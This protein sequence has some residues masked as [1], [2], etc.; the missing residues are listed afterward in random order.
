LEAESTEAKLRSEIDALKQ[1]LVSQQAAHAHQK[2]R[3]S[4]TVLVLI[5]L[6]VVVAAVGAFFTGF[7]PHQRRQAALVAEEKTEEETAPVVNVTPVERSSGNSQL[8]LPGNI[9]AITEA[10][11]LS[12]ASGYVKKRLADIGDRV[13][14]GQV[15][16]E[17]DA[18]EMDNQ[19]RQVQATLEQTRASQEQAGA[20]LVQARTN[21]KLYKTTSERYGNLLQKGAVSRQEFDNFT[22]QYQAQQAAVQAMEKGVNVAR[23]NIAVAEANL[24]R[25]TEMQSYLKVKAPFAGVITVRNVDTGAL[26]NEGSTLL[27][28]IAQTDRLRIYVNVPQSDAS[29]IKVG[30]AAK[31]TVSDM[32]SKEFLGKVTRTANSLDPSNRTL[33]VEVQVPNATN[34]LMPGMYAQVNFSTPRSEP[35]ML[36]RGDALIIRANGPQVAVVMP[37]STVH[38]QVIALGRDYGDR[39]EVLSGLKAGQQLVINPGDNIQ[40]K[41]KVRP[42]LVAPVKK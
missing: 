34:T 18:A 41:G 33:L 4:G 26:V 10:P 9:Q 24:A 6:L 11:I 28:R 25:L 30:Q 29:G 13:K 37:D 36:I 5:G 38:F 23:S 16:A 3:P 15:L 21:E 35:P 32:A 19:V 22:A 2:R 17:V 39:I 12:R 31:V 42:V 8:V 20:N 7:I 14:E 1:K 40:E 27:Y